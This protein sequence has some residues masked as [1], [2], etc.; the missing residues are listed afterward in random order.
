[1]N[2]DGYSDLMYR[3]LDGVLYV[4]ADSSGAH[5]YTINSSDRN[6]M[7]KDIITPGDLDGSGKPEVL[8]LSASG[9]L[10]LHQSQGPE[11][12]GHVS[13][14]GN[15]WQVYSKVFSPGDLDGD[16]IGDLLARTTWGGLSTYKGTGNVGSTPFKKY[17][18]A[19]DRNWHRYD[20]IV[21]ANDVNGDGIGDVFARTPAGD[22]YFYAGTGDTA[23]LFK[24]HVKVGHGFGIHNQ[25]VGADDIDGDGL[26]R[27]RMGREGL[28]RTRDAA[29]AG[30]PG[31]KR[32]TPG[33]RRWLGR[34]RGGE[35][36]GARGR[37]NRVTSWACSSRPRFTSE[38]VMG[39][40]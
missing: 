27:G 35:E 26:S 15:G 39:P 1:M 2:G 17:A 23:K 16:G 38:R 31:G 4:N 40:C 22:L 8:T 14:S 30:I 11:G 7:F 34:R 25:L 6:E 24:P 33:A 3:G 20:Q 29:G 21:G 19:P 37:R 9:K 12:T 36:L 10:S 28:R 32:P 13:W 5:P 18:E